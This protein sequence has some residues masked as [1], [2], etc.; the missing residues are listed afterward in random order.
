M[1]LQT[2]GHKLQNGMYKDRQEFEADF[3]LMIQNCRTYNPPGSYPYTES[4]ALEVFFDKGMLRCLRL[5]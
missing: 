1:D 2:M 3:R 4:V 5:V